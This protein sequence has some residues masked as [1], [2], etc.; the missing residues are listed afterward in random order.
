[1]TKRCG[2]MSYHFTQGEKNRE[3]DKE[4]EKKKGKEERNR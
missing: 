3:K 2:R 4:K 1:V